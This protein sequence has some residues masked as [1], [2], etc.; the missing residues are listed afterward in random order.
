MAIAMMNGSIMRWG[1]QW[2]RGLSDQVWPDRYEPRPDCIPSLPEK[3]GHSCRPCDSHPW[4]RFL[5][6]WSWLSWLV[7]F[8]VIVGHVIPDKLASLSCP[9]VVG[10]TL[11]VEILAFAYPIPRVGADGEEQE[12]ECD[13]FEC[14]GHMCICYD[15][16]RRVS[17]PIRSM[18]D[19][20]I[21]EKEC[22]MISSIVRGMEKNAER[23][24][25]A[26]LLFSIHDP[27]GS[28]CWLII[29]TLHYCIDQ[30]ASSRIF[31]FCHPRSVAPD[32][33]L[34]I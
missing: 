15:L 24:M 33:F 6:R 22:S 21:W 10:A 13:C 7:V 25:Y 14:L 18:L 16:R 9:L 17:C 5:C 27:S 1:L 28:R 32:S 31:F 29:V 30:I 4:I 11:S 8:D 12:W 19:S 26:P 20:L 23:M 3:V 34:F 2:Y